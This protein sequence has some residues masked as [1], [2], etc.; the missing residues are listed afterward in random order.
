[1]VCTSPD[2]LPYSIQELLFPSHLCSHLYCQGPLSVLSSDIHALYLQSQSNLQ[3]ALTIWSKSR[4]KFAVES[5]ISLL[6]SLSPDDD[7]IYEN[8]SWL[9]V[10]DVANAVRIFHLCK[11]PRVIQFLESLDSSQSLIAAYLESRIDE[12]DCVDEAIHTLLAKTYLSIHE[13]GS[14]LLQEFLQRSTRYNALDLLNAVQSS[15]LRLIHEQIILLSRLGEHNQVQRLYLIELE[16]IGK[17]CMECLL[18]LN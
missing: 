18:L 1:M 8:A 14:T 4:S 10:E 17:Q 7:L 13:D 5:S 2:L 15:G 9:L 12:D 3:D 11:Q 16:D 6:R